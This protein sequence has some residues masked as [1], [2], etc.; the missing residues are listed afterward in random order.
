MTCCRIPVRITTYCAEMLD[1]TWKDLVIYGEQKPM[2]HLAPFTIDTQI[3]QQDIKVTFT[4]S[5][6]VFS[7]EKGSGPLLF[8]KAGRY[9]SNERYEASLKLPGMLHSNF[10]DA[11]VTPYTDKGQNEQYHYLEMHDYAIFF[12]VKN[13]AHNH[14]HVVI[15]S[16]YDVNEWGKGGLPK[17]GAVKSRFIL[18]LKLQ[19]MT[20]YQYK[21]QKRP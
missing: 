5:N 15:I 7:D 6:H 18:D 19:G 16:A 17:G 2:G 10:L 21:K 4:Y 9:F 1:R 20:Y 12:D 13:H 11:Y 3:G 14:L 8:K